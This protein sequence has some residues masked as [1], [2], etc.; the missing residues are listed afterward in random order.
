MIIVITWQVTFLLTVAYSCDFSL[1]TPDKFAPKYFAESHVTKHNDVNVCV[2]SK[3]SN[4]TIIQSQNC[5]WKVTLICKNGFVWRRCARRHRA[6]FTKSMKFDPGGKGSQE[7]HAMKRAINITIN[8]R[9]RSFEV[10]SLF[11]WRLEMDAVRSQMCGPRKRHPCAH[12]AH[13]FG[14][15]TQ[16]RE[17]TE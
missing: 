6:G 14:S 17:P 15:G 12:L 4:K 13:V 11:F 2:E 10:R 1:I 5:T 8:E 9:I 3:T 16:K 7:N